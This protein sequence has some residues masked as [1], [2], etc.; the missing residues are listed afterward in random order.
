MKKILT[1]LTSF[2]QRDSQPIIRRKRPIGQSLIEFAI[3]LPVLVVILSGMMEFGFIL[4]FYMSLLDATRGAARYAS[5]ADPFNVNGTDRLDYYVTT[6]ELVRTE[7][8]PP[9]TEG[10]RIILDP[11]TDG[12]IVTVYC[13][14][15]QSGAAVAT[16]Y[17]DSGPYNTNPS[18]IS[19]AF[20]AQSIANTYLTSAPNSG[21]VLVEVYYGYRPVI[22]LFY[23][24]KVTLRAHSIMPA[25]SADP[26][27]DCP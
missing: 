2:F 9:T 17:P 6:A 8:D 1:K 11:S 10:R 26:A 23:R 18:K 14:K 15:V 22:G 21:L 19:S 7:L 20:T 25:N 13:V 24:N 5:L 3:A 4:N 12:V 27:P 16:S